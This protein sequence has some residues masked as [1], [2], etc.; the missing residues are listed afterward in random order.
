MGLAGLP[1]CS[2]KPYKKKLFIPAYSKPVIY[3]K[4]A[5]GKVPVSCGCDVFGGK[6]V[7]VRKHF[8]TNPVPAGRCVCQF[9]CGNPSGCNTA[10]LRAAPLCCKVDRMAN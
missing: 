7:L 3:G 2:I 9:E 8:I 1:R 6:G 10:T 4:C 5:H